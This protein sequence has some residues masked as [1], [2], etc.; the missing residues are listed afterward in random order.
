MTP[1]LDDL[2]LELQ[3]GKIRTCSLR[4]PEFHLDGMQIGEWVYI[5]E[6]PAIVEAVLHELIHRRYPK[7][8]ETAV[9]KASRALLA[10]MS[11]AD[12]RKWFT[13]YRRIRK[14]AKPLELAED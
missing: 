13:A 1:T 8:T 11:D 7:M 9:L 5:D 10:R 14:V 12:L 2:W 6:R 4:D 3:R